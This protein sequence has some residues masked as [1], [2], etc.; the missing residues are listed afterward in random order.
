MKKLINL[1]LLSVSLFSL[2]LSAV[3]EFSEVKESFISSESSV[4]DIDGFVIQ[5]GRTNTKERRLNW[6]TLSEI[7]Y[8][9]VKTAVIA[10]D[11]RFYEHSGVDWTAFASGTVKFFI[12]ESR[13]AST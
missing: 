1:F 5:E 6:I 12:G 11:K 3:P 10:E 7:S 8:H 9:L 2:R 13:G 4:L